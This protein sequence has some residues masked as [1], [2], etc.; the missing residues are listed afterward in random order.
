MAGIAPQSD[1]AARTAQIIGAD[2][3]LM[4]D[5]AAR[6]TATANRRGLINSSIGIGAA[7]KEVLGVAVPIASQESAQAASADNLKTQLASTEG[8]AARDLTSREQLATAQITSTEGMARRELTSREK[9]SADQLASSENLANLDRTSR[10]KLSAD[11]ISSNEGMSARDIASRESM[12]TAQIAAAER[13]RLSNNQTTLSGNYQQA[14]T[15]TLQNDKIPATERASVL[16]AIKADYNKA[17]LSMQ[18]LYGI[19]PA[20]PAPNT[21]ENI[22]AV[23]DPYQGYGDY[24]YTQR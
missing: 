8:I 4:R 18:Q 21:S 23:Y 9:L 15:A 20:T 19:A 5:A 13:E 22:G 14:I 6:G 10:E 1:I 16:A 11:Q 2:S 7:Q 17:V 12:N 3:A 24:W